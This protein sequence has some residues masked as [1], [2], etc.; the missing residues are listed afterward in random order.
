MARRRK[1]HDPQAPRKV[2]RS[3]PRRR[4]HWQP[5]DPHELDVMI[6]EAEAL[7]QKLPP[8]VEQ[9]QQVARR[10]TV[11]M[12][13]WE[14]LVAKE[15]EAQRVFGER[16]GRVKHAEHLQ[17]TLAVLRRR[18]L[19]TRLQALQEVLQLVAWLELD[20]FRDDFMHD[21]YASLDERQQMT[22]VSDV[23]RARQDLSDGEE[24][25]SRIRQLLTTG[26]GYFETFSIRKRAL[27][28]AMMALLDAVHLHK[29]GQP[30][31]EELIVTT[32]EQVQEALRGVRPGN[33]LPQEVQEVVQLAYWGPYVKYRWREDSKG[34]L[35]TVALGKISQEP[36]GPDDNPDLLESDNPEEL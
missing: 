31:P 29:E 20:I 13:T 5:G 28:S 30:I 27:S 16:F 8:L 3:D 1:W 19:V 18:R 26:N 21:L 11:L 34:P 24:R 14:D 22:L 33:P 4:Q 15:E 10:A 17:A 2:A 6:D 32:P 7:Y 25:L 35:Y 23:K 36:A 12:G 9:M